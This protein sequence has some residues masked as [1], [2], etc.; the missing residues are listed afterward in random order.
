MRALVFNNSYYVRKPA[1]HHISADAD[2]ITALIIFL[3]AMYLFT[4]DTRVFASLV[5]SLSLEA[6]VHATEDP[7][8]VKKAVLNLIPPELR[9][10]VNLLEASVR[11]HYRNPI[12]I[13]KL[14]VSDPSKAQRVITYIAEG[15]RGADKRYIQSTLSLRVD[16]TRTLYLRFNKQEAYLGRLRL[17]D[18]NDVIRLRVKLA[19]SK[20]IKDI[21]R[22]LG[23]IP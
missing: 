7:R 16:E 20:G 6:F 13:L 1:Y 18:S 19:S 21:C 15:L 3:T 4:W 23:L 10:S 9:D 8:K 12:R 5:R 11:G 2:L 17:D 14:E 22:E